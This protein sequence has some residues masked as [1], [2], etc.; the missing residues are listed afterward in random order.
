MR[1]SAGIPESECLPALPEAPTGLP[2]DPVG[3][4]LNTGT[5]DTLPPP[6]LL[7][8]RPEHG[9]D[10][11]QAEIFENWPKPAPARNCGAPSRGVKACGCGVQIIR[12]HC[13]NLDCSNP[14]CEGVNRTRRA[15]D[16]FDILESGR[17][18]RRAIYF[19]GTLPPGI[20]DRYAKQPAWQKLLRRWIDRLKKD[21]N[22]DYGA[23]RSDPCGDDMVTWHPHINLLWVRKDG[24]GWIPED[25]ISRAWK[26]TL[27]SQDLREIRRATNAGEL[28]LEESLGK[29]LAFEAQPIDIHLEYSSDR[30]KI[31]FWCDYLGRPWP[32]WA[33]AHKY[34]L[35]VKWFGNRPKKLLLEK[36]HD[37]PVCGWKICTL[38]LGT[39]DA[40]RQ[41]AAMGYARIRD[42][43][44]ER[45]AV[46]A[47]SKPAKFQRFMARVSAAGTSWS[48]EG[49]P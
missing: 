43:C 39:E 15:M 18:G 11:F 30:A 23:E 31:N 5:F 6:Q 12:D 10:P 17:R 2:A 8:F 49:A 27:Y 21:F 22:F 32:R 41:M 25:E 34:M 48:R 19:V 9:S 14:Y 29:L 3:L 24:A 36:N 1:A 45:L 7:D 33:R 35:R 47:R 46:F 16:A 28:S 37:C 42:E 38:Q 40:A 13:D 26:E 44:D 20:R 4:I